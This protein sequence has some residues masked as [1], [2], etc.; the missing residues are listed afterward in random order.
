MRKYLTLF[1]MSWQKQ[2]EV[3][4]DFIFERGRS[5]AVLFSLYYLWSSLL[6]N[7]SDVAG[8]S[9]AEMLTYVLMMTL[10]RA[11][12]LSAVT[13]RIP[14]E[15]SQG[16]LSEHLLRP[17]SHMGYWAT[18]DAASKMLNIGSFFVEMALFVLI[19]R[20]PLLAPASAP[21]LA[22]FVASTLLAM[23]IYFRMSYML[24]VMGFWTAQS[25]GPRFCFEI[26]LEFS[27]G[28]YFP[29]DLLPA[30]AQRMIGFLPFP[31]LVFHPLQ[32]Y[33][34]KAGPDAWASVLGHQIFWVGAL[35][36]LSRALWGAGLRR[37]AAEGG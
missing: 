17:M 9:R 26:I 21:A 3:R 20:P 19:V 1:G 7:R 35:T 13:D 2:L 27:A 23:V 16:K 5:L 37:Y 6:T 14:S 25:W 4:S 11:W 24:G 29:I 32:I 31:Y 30:A 12:V 33:L 15:I 22:A 10:L 18:Q 28:A 34:G 36:F 8:Y